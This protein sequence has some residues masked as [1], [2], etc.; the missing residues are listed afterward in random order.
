MRLNFVQSQ[1]S[2]PFVEFNLAKDFFFEKGS[3][4][5]GEGHYLFL[6]GLTFLAFTLEA[7]LNHLGSQM[8][9]DWNTLER[10]TSVEMKL[11]IVSKHLGLAFDI[12]QDPWI[13][14]V[15]IRAFRNPVA[16]GKN[17]TLETTAILDAP[18]DFMAFE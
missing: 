13:A 10:S 18:A 12:S 16:H 5:E 15:H 1:N 14:A 3:A 11:D 4:E 9:R 6:A 7:Y 2:I 17:S 8:F